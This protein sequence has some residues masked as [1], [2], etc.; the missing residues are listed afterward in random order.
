MGKSISDHTTP[1]ESPT[2]IINRLGAIF[3]IKDKVLVTIRAPLAGPIPKRHPRTPTIIRAPSGT[4][5][6]RYF[7][8]SERRIGIAILR[9]KASC[10]AEKCRKHHQQRNTKA[11][12]FHI[13]LLIVPHRS[14]FP[15]PFISNHSHVFS[16]NSVISSVRIATRK[17]SICSN[18]QPISY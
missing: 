18:R 17:Q 16:I 7:A 15:F 12:H 9:Y 6:L 3:T 8:A 11:L 5:R 10:W 1:A 13:F 2:F 14:R 4:N